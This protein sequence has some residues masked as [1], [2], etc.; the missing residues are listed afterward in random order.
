MIATCKGFLEIQTDPSDLRWSRVDFIHRTAAEF[1]PENE[2]GRDILDSQ[3]SADSNAHVLHV[4]A[5]LARL[6][7]KDVHGVD[8][9][10]HHSSLEI[11]AGKTLGCVSQFEEATGKAF[12]ALTELVYRILSS[13]NLW[14]SLPVG[15]CWSTKCRWERFAKPI[16]EANDE[17]LPSDP[18]DFLRVT[19]CYGLRLY[20]LH[21]LD[22]C[23]AVYYSRTT[24]YLLCCT[25]KGRFYGSSVTRLKLMSVLL[26]RG[27]SPNLTMGEET[28]WS[29]FLTE[30]YHNLIYEKTSSQSHV[31][32]PPA[33]YGDTILAFLE[34]N[35]DT[36]SS[37]PFSLSGLFHL[38]LHDGL[39]ESSSESYW[40]MVREMELEVTPLIMLKQLFAYSSDLNRIEA[41]CHARD[42]P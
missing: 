25:T 42:I 7:L 5:L 17:I 41:T 3:A 40:V 14:K 37:I 20:V 31:Y 38:E 21:K 11:F 22:S 4:K 12:F 26:R 13:P 18:N 30:S 9:E 35:A 36:K 39:Q 2:F 28:V 29:I 8:G 34:S 15:V 19:A 23:P 32:E 24:E 1:L 16:G 6:I 10:H 33:D 27:A